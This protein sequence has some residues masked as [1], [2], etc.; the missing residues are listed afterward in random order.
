VLT[1]A[2]PVEIAMPRDRDASFEPVIAGRRQRRMSGVD[3]LV[4]SL[5]AN[6]SVSSPQVWRWRHHAA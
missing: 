3:D 2:G 6:S 1:E 5:A 4:I